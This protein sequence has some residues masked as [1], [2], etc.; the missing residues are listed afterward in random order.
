MKR[1]CDTSFCFFYSD[2]CIV[3]K[4]EI[5]SY[6]IIVNIFVNIFGAAKNKKTCLEIIRTGFFIKY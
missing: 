1:I 4:P 3:S 5:V 2:N 6:K